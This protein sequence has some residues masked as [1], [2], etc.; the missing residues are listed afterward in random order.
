MNNY[1]VNYRITFFIKDEKL[2]TEK[3]YGEFASILSSMHLCKGKKEYFPLIKPEGIFRQTVA[4]FA[5]Y[6]KGIMVKI[7]NGRIDINV[8]KTAKEELSPLTDQ[9]V[10]LCEMYEVLLKKR[11]DLLINRVACCSTYLFDGEDKE[12]QV[13]YGK[14]V[15]DFGDETPVEWTLQRIS[16]IKDTFDKYPAPITNNNLIKRLNIRGRFEEEAHN[17]IL[18]EIDLNSYPQADA[19]FNEEI[20]KKFLIEMP[21]KEEETFNKIQ[22]KLIG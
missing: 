18:V 6:E 12:L 19:I 21:L 5:N 20:I 22:S 15:N 14:L 2:D 16:Q 17:R 8:Q 4:T 9:M 11:K 10:V 3:E 1:P 13:C 7:Q